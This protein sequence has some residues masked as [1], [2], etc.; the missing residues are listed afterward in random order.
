MPCRAATSRQR[1][2]GELACIGEHYRDSTSTTARDC[3][4]LKL[5]QGARVER[6]VHRWTYVYNFATLELYRYSRASLVVTDVAA[7]ISFRLFR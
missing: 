1:C 2:L 4:V 6:D 3:T 5:P 7:R